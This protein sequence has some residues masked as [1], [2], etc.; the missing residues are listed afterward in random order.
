MYLFELVTYIVKCKM[1]QE[2]SI[3]KTN[4]LL[5]KIPVRYIGFE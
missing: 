1:T 3:K 2:R 5:Y 4:F